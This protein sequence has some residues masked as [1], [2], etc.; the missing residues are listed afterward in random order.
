MSIYKL[1]TTVD[2]KGKINLPLSMK[3][4]FSRKVRITLTDIEKS[5]TNKRNP[6]QILTDI[7]SKYKE[8]KESEIDV[9]D[10]FS[11]RDQNHE[12]TFGFD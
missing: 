6:V 10:I 3:S 11:N 1:E 5:K 12:R 8:I 9:S 2:E 4:I 7:S